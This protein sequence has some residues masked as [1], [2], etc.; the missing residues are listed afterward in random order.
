MNSSTKSCNNCEYQA[1]KSDPQS[2]MVCLKHKFSDCS[3]T[4]DYP[5][6][7]LKES[8]R[9]ANIYLSKKNKVHRKNLTYETNEEAQKA[10][11][12]QNGDCYLGTIKLH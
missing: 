6:F 2:G 12:I 5:Y 11:T 10:I 7:K 4:N 9:Y 8:N 1:I 3:M